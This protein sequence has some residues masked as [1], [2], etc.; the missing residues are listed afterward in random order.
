MGRAQARGFLHRHLAPLVRHLDPRTGQGLFGI[1]GHEDGRKDHLGEV[2][3]ANGQI[4]TVDLV[5]V[6]RPVGRVRVGRVA[7][8]EGVLGQDAR[9][10]GGGSRVDAGRAGNPEGQGST[11]VRVWRHLEV[12]TDPAHL[13]RTERPDRDEEVV[14][15]LVE[16]RA[17]EGVVEGSRTCAVDSLPLESADRAEEPDVLVEF[18]SAAVRIISAASVESDIVLE[19]DSPGESVAGFQGAKIDRC[20]DAGQGGLNLP[21]G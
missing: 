6:G 10:V 9:R 20:D 4:P 7:G 8:L 17:A 2:A 5:V 21:G 13:A 11:T 1:L 19:G 16:L 14:P 3:V 12:E 18:D 15:H